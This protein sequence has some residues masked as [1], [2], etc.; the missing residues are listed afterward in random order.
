MARAA[1]GAHRCVSIHGTPDFEAA[2]RRLSTVL[3]GVAGL[4][5]AC[6]RP[7]APLALHGVSTATVP[8]RLLLLLPG[9]GDREDAPEVG[10]ARAPS[11]HVA[12]QPPRNAVGASTA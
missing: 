6:H 2:W 1:D 10:A 9:Q 5:T 3:H 7:A 8:S 11:P 4:C 12:P